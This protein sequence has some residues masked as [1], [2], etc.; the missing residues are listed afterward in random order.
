MDTLLNN[1][2]IWLLPIV[3]PVVAA[4]AV[5]PMLG[6]TTA[7]ALAPWTALPALVL[8]LMPQA[9]RAI[10]V[11]WLLLGSRLGLDEIARVILFVTAVLWLA[12]GIFAVSYFAKDVR[13]HRFLFFF[14]LA[15]SGNFGLIL[16][17]DMVLFYVCFALMSFA[18][19]GLVVFTADR[20]AVRAGR[21]YIV[22]VIVGELL[23]FSGLVVAAWA[24]GSTLWVGLGDRLADARF[25][26]IAAVLLFGGLAIKAG[27]LP[28]HVWLP[29]AH[30]AAPVPA[31]AV[32]SGAM[33]KAGLIGWLRLVPSE[34]GVAL[35]GWAELCLVL[36]IAA[37]FYGVVVGITQTN[38]KTVLA[39]SSISQMG[40][41]TVAVGLAVS[42]ASPQLALV[43]VL[44][45]AMH[46]GFAKGALFLGVGVV[47]ATGGARWPRWLWSLGLLLP[48]LALAGL[49]LTSGALAK[50]MLKYHVPAAPGDWPEAL[51]IL[52]PIAAVGTTLLMARFLAIM[53][54]NARHAAK[55]SPT[56]AWLS[57]LLLILF[58][59]FGAFVWPWG[60]EFAFGK[61]AFSLS[62]IWGKLWPLVGGVAIAVFAWVLSRRFRLALPTIP[63]G[64]VLVVAVAAATALWRGCHSVTQLLLSDFPWRHPTEANAAMVAS[65]FS[66]LLQMVERNLQRSAVV[67]VVLLILIWL[68]IGLFAFSGSVVL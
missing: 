15:M 48:A 60:D 26:G 42:S 39:Y 25:G 29:L 40:L 23:L 9:T 1:S 58:V 61:H 55:A 41:I 11:P 53:W 18:S 52:L 33:I 37:A 30:P 56:G 6:R 46:H 50:S 51:G 7:M 68:L 57:W 49:P 64:D 36:G 19:Y 32:L 67:G 27:A 24:T 31:S 3:L 28:L 17:Q 4:C 34:G 22:L 66:D 38:P 14:L 47:P 63:A 13:R 43:P 62:K 2:F 65:R 5:L 16:A 54:S 20:E 12:S 59:A 21:V 8:S 44:A 35:V 10:D 45:Y